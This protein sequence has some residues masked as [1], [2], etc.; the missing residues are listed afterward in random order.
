MCVCLHLCPDSLIKPIGRGYDQ[1]T[2]D[3]TIFSVHKLLFARL[4]VLRFSIHPRKANCIFIFVI[5]LFVQHG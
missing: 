2:H 3:A 5:M 1:L 4:V